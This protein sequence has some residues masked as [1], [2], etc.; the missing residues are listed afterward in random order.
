LNP[1]NWSQLA[2]TITTGT[3]RTIKEYDKNFI[4]ALYKNITRD[5][6]TVVPMDGR[7]I[8]TAQREGISKK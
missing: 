8:E 6:L 4:G 2:S 7:K 3:P 1:Q 5:K